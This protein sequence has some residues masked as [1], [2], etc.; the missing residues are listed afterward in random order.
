MSPDVLVLVGMGDLMTKQQ[1]LI[2]LPVATDQLGQENIT[3]QSGQAP[4]S[5]PSV[6]KPIKLEDFLKTF[7]GTGTHP[8]THKLHLRSEIIMHV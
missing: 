7:E 5:N 3:S 4:F 6:T 1:F 2:P 8:K